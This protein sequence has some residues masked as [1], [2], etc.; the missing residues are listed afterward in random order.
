M[1]LRGYEHQVAEKAVA[2]GSCSGRDRGSEW[3]VGMSMDVAGFPKV[4]APQT[5][6]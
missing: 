4:L 6:R 1:L 3:R 2:G 5:P